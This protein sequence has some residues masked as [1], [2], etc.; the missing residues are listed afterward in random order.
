M[1]ASTSAFF[2][3][4]AVL[5]VYGIYLAY[6][7]GAGGLFTPTN[8]AFSSVTAVHAAPSTVPTAEGLSTPF[9]RR[10]TS[11]DADVITLF[12]FVQCYIAFQIF[13]LLLWPFWNF[14][15]HGFKLRR[16]AWISSLAGRCRTSFML[17]SWLSGIDTSWINT[18]LVRTR[19]S[20]GRDRTKP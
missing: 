1:S 7:H 19:R 4:L 12:N 5:L 20:Q 8:A 11:Y 14:Y 17:E 15:R 10:P 18:V 16:L 3:A 13:I 6:Y 9:S 2:R